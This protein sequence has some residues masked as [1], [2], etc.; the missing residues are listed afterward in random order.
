MCL[1]LSRG[2]CC[3]QRLCRPTV[4]DDKHCRASDSVVVACCR[5]GINHASVH[6]TWRW[7]QPSDTSRDVG[8]RH[9]RWVHVHTD[10]VAAAAADQ[11]ERNAPIATPYVEH[12][13]PPPPSLLLL[14][15]VRAQIGGRRRP[16]NARATAVLPVRQRPGVVALDDVALR[17]GLQQRHERAV[18]MALRRDSICVSGAPPVSHSCPR[19]HDAALAMAGFFFGRAGGAIYSC[20]LPLHIA[21][22]RG[23]IGIC[24]GASWQPPLARKRAR[25]AT[26][27][28][29]QPLD[30]VEVGSTAGS[31]VRP[32]HSHGRG[33]S[34]RARC[35]GRR[36]RARR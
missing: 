14:L 36:G 28:G 32:H 11:V 7:R 22:R 29:S 2:D 25:A 20:A 4:A 6:R 13:Q 23:S 17:L 24:A 16:A 33:T 12:A 31:A 5:P 21:S 18:E 35:M 30:S 3:S 26:A 15:L 27:G 19:A 1:L 9:R 8:C 10:H 34:A